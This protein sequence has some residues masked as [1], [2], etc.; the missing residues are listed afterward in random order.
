MLPEKQ[1]SSAQRGK[2]EPVCSGCSSERADPRL[3]RKG[4][5]ACGGMVPQ[6]Q[7]SSAERGKPKPVCSGCKDTRLARRCHGAWDCGVRSLANTPPTGSERFCLRGGFDGDYVRK[8]QV[9]LA[10]AGD[11]SHKSSASP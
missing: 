6:K 11:L 3:V 2:P 5:G 4:Y 10:G 9:F 8:T 1:F 7:F